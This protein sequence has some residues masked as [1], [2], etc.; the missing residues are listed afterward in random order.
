MT[1]KFTMRK[2]A[3]IAIASAICAM[4]IPFASPAMAD[5][6]PTD[7]GTGCS[8]VH[9]VIAQGTGQS[10]TKNSNDVTDAFVEGKLAVGMANKFPGKVTSW[11]VNYP[12]SAG[13]L[14]S[15]IA[16]NGETTT[17]GDSRLTGAKKVVDHITEYRS[18]CGD[19]K[20]MLTGFSQGASVAGD[21]AALIA[22]GASSNTKSDDIMGVVLFADPGRSG[23][24]Q[25]TGTK[26]ATAYIPLPKGARY[27]RNGEYVTEGHEEDTVGLTGQRSLPFTGLEGR[28]IS[29]CSPYDLACTV[30]DG[31]ILRDGADLSDKNWLPEPTNYRNNA[32]ILSMTLEGKLTGILTGVLANNSLDKVSNGDIEGFLDDYHNLVEKDTTLSADEKA[33]LFNAE[34]EIRYVISL[35]KSEKGYGPNA[36][37]KAILSHVFQQVGTKIVEH[38]AVPKEY[39]APLSAF[40]SAMSSGDTSSIPEDTKK[41]MASTLKY[42]LDFPENHGAYFSDKS[43][44][45]V[46][47]GS[48]EQWVTQAVEK[49]I[50]NVLDGTPYEVEPGSNPRNPGDAIEQSDP[51][52]LDDGLRGIVD[53]NFNSTNFNPANALGNPGNGITDLGSRSGLRNNQ[54]SSQGGGASS[55]DN[56]STSRD[57]DS[58]SRSDRKKNKKK[59]IKELSSKYADV[60]ESNPSARGEQIQGTPATA[61]PAAGASEVGPKVNTGGSVSASFFDKVASL[62]KAA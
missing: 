40:V 14:H 21:A 32:G 22:N 24:S 34:T 13:A 26:G 43:N 48:A 59:P 3:G 36:S 27:Q 35:L 57:S 30:K 23:N 11:Q 60:V 25:Y 47:G 42:A 50:Q 15:A 39:K 29:L 33:T 10:A 16:K 2:T 18:K 51:N 46:A 49:G 17:Y 53:P 45:K 6:V 9:I 8:P 7:Q 19:S 54:N 4:S 58:D 31:T 38:E 56:A 12:S 1:L 20:I 5:D 61:Q 44:Y 52:R 28:V 41:R 55:S 37:N 62:F